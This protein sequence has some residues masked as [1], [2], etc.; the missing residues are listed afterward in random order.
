[1]RLCEWFSDNLTNPKPYPDSGV[2]LSSLANELA[3]VKNNF[4]TLVGFSVWA[5]GAFDT[6]YVLTQTPFKNG[7]DQALWAAAGK[8]A[9]RCS[10]LNV[11]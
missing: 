8:F 5:A 7:T 1:M 3:F 10:G 4:P 6:T 11:D 9:Q 2:S